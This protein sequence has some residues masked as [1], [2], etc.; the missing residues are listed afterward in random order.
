MT[1]CI[2]DVTV[3]ISIMFCCFIAGF[4]CALQ[5]GERFKKWWSKEI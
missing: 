5:Y 4:V 3:P 1:E 2:C